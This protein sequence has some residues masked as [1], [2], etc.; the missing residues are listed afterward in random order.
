MHSQNGMSFVN[1]PLLIWKTLAKLFRIH[2]S[3]GAERWALRPDAWGVELPYHGHVRQECGSDPCAWNFL[4]AWFRQW[5]HWCLQGK[6]L[7]AYVIEI[8][9]QFNFFKSMGLTIKFIARYILERESPVFKAKCL[10]LHRH[11]KVRMAKAMKSEKPINIPDVT[12]SEFETLLD[13]LYNV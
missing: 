1:C 8:L 3:L 12:C 2:Q 10:A 5:S 9:I 7:T 4:L 6:R 11:L 13:F